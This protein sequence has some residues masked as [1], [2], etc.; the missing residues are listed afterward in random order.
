MNVELRIAK[1]NFN[2]LKHYSYNNYFRNRKKLKYHH[3]HRHYTQWSDE[4]KNCGVSDI[5]VS[6]NTLTSIQ[7]R[8]MKMVAI[9]AV[10]I[11]F[12]GTYSEDSVI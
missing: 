12:P 4:I 10:L 7:T 11:V 6:Y 1:I 9:F 2:K 8:K 5:V 3:H